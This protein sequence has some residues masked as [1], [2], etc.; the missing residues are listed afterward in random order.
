[1]GAATKKAVT[2]YQKSLGVE[3]SAIL[4]KTLES[5]GIK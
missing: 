3:S 2:D 5:L 4:L 1:M